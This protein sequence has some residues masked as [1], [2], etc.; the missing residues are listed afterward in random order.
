MKKNYSCS[1]IVLLTISYRGISS[2][3]A[4]LLYLQN[5][6]KLHLYGV[7]LIK[8]INEYKERVRIGVCAS[9]IIIFKKNQQIDYKFSWPKI[10]KVRCQDY[11][12][13]LKIKSSVERED[14]IHFFIFPSTSIAKTFFRNCKEHHLFFRCSVQ[15][16][17]KI[18]NSSY[19][20]IYDDDEMNDS[21]KLSYEEQS[22]PENESAGPIAA[23]SMP[24]IVKIVTKEIINKDKNG[25]TQNTEEM[26]EDGRTGE[27]T[28]TTQMNKVWF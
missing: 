20:T 5:V 11:N 3:A 9:G 12:F 23:S 21:F 2:S 25:V 8:V 10:N 17:E 28:H 6:K 13:Y 26:I 22:E 7:H 14:G 24:V 4:Q 16:N 1:E 18:F 27:I 15:S 19:G